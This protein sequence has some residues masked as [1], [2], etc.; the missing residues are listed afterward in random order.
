MKRTSV[1]CMRVFLSCSMACLLMVT[2]TTQCFRVRAI[3]VPGIKE[4][5]LKILRHLE[6]LGFQK[7]EY[8]I[9]R[10]SDIDEKG[11]WTQRLSHLGQL[12]DVQELRKEIAKHGG[13]QVNLVGESRGA[14][15]SLNWDAVCTDSER[16]LVK[17]IVA[18]AP[19]TCIEDFPSKNLILLRI[20]PKTLKPHVVRKGIPMIREGFP[21]YN[22]LG[23][24]PIESIKRGKTPT[25]LITSEHDPIVHAANCKK[26]YQQAKNAGRTNVHLLVVKGYKHTGNLCDE[27][28]QQ[29]VHA[30][31]AY[32]G[33]DH[34][35]VLAEKG[36]A[37]FAAT[38]PAITKKKSFALWSWFTGN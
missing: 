32:Y 26:L 25:L 21:L 38:Q 5:T 12:G 10:F 36:K 16:K 31:W 17:T 2:L 1:L 30:F 13:L 23:L 22:T 15:T 3:G 24:H 14:A 29:V 27:H 33:A 6:S 35:T 4:N 18:E 34:D 20:L 19:F 8:A 7:N 37:L 11:K 28:V 9:V